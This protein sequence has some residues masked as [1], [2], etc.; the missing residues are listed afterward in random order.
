MDTLCVNGKKHFMTRT[1]ASEHFRVEHMAQIWPMTINPGTSVCFNTQ[2][3]QLI[4]GEPVGP[5]QQILGDAG[6]S[7]VQVRSYV[8]PAVSGRS[9]LLPK[10]N[11]H[12]DRNCGSHLRA[13]SA[14]WLSELE[15][16]YC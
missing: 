12:R 8:S 2:I 5:L 16:W 11:G 3:V 6:A 15:G 7:L 1:T 4:P 10:E 9:L 13:L 14:Q